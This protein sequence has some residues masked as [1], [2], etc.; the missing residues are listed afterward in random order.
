MWRETPL[1]YLKRTPMGL[2]QKGHHREL[3]IGDVQLDASFNIG[4]QVTIW[5]PVNDWGYMDIISPLSNEL[6]AEMHFIRC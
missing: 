6:Q 5:T 4:H 2:N 1:I 3:P